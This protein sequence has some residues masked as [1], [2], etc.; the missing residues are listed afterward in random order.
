MCGSVPRWGAARICNRHSTH[1]QTPNR[2]QSA[3]TSAAV[4]VDIDSAIV[5][6]G[7][8]GLM[9]AI[10]S[11]RSAPRGTR[12]VLLD[13]AK[14][15]GAKILVA[16]GGRCNVT[17]QVVSER[18]YAGSTPAAIRKVLRSF[19]VAETI[20]FFR[21]LGLEL[22]TEETGKLFPVT[23]QARTVLDAPAAR[24]RPGGR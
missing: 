15:L 9:S 23:D 12:I 18:D 13:G 19:P 6:G 7:A 2:A 11:G 17:H 5:G 20:G 8:A 24:L 16:G 3:Y 14:S 10:W 21:E 4:I 1:L 22:K